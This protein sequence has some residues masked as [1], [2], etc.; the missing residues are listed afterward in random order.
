MKGS[1]AA[2]W[3][4]LIVH[5][6]PSKGCVQN[7]RERGLGGNSLA[8]IISMCLPTGG[9][10]L[11]YTSRHVETAEDFPRCS[12]QLDKGGTKLFWKFT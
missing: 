3:N 5:R 9:P 10:D 2:V 11:W 6:Q 4:Y 8:K 7:P 1:S 12:I